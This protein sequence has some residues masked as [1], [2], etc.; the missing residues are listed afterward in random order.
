MR[1]VT[2]IRSYVGHKLE[3]GPITIAPWKFVEVNYAD[4]Q[5]LSP[6]VQQSLNRAKLTRDISIQ[7][8]A[9]GN[10]VDE[11]NEST[12]VRV[13]RESVGG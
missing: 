6:D 12:V 3:F 2:V 5:A 8:V 10:P 13:W 4:Y 11:M 1:M 7:L 9:D